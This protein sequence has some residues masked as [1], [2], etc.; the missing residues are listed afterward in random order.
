MIRQLHRSA[1][2]H[3]N[4]GKRLRKLP[5][6]VGLLEIRGAHSTGPR[7]RSRRTDAMVLMA[8][9]DSLT[10]CE[11]AC[12]QA[13]FF[14]TRPSPWADRRPG[15]TIGSNCLKATSGYGRAKADFSSAMKTRTLCGTYL[16]VGYSAHTD[17]GGRT[18]SSSWIGIKLPSAISSITSHW[19]IMASPSP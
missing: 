19:V 17:R 8:A 11:A 9:H 13:P 16:R 18:A 12:V 6:R 7:W 3:Q 4:A 15:P 14:L 2:P 5:G 1:M 10:R